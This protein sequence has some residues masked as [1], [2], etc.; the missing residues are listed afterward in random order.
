MRSLAYG[1]L[2]GLGAGSA[3][4]GCG[5]D[6]TLPT[7]HFDGVNE[8]GYVSY[9]EKIAE[10]DLGDGLVIPIAINFNSHRES[11]SPTL[12]KGWMMTLLESH[13]EP[14]DE[15]TMKVIMPHGWNY[16]FLR[17][18]NTETWGGNA[19]W[20]GQTDG[21]RFTITA[22]CGWRVK[23]DGGKIQE[24]DSP[25]SRTIT[26]KYNGPV[27]TEADIDNKPFL[28]VESDTVTGVAQD[29]II[30]GQKITIA[31][32]QRPRIQ[33]VNNQNLITGFDPSL[34]QL[35]YPDGK[36]ETY[37]FATPKDLT[38]TL[39][40]TQ[41]GHPARGITWD[42]AT[43]QIKTDGDW[44]YQLI[45]AANVELNRTN[46]KGQKEYYYSDPSIGTTVSE[47]MDG[48]KKVTRWFT[49]GIL[50]GKIRSI[51][52]TKADKAISLQRYSY[53]EK[54][55]ILREQV[56]GLEKIYKNGQLVSVSLNG[57]LV[58]IIKYIQ[59]QKDT[60]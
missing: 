48:I 13:V 47:S 30:A 50:A 40:I 1:F 60:E 9:W 32:D 38:P 26:I 21:S 42:P 2:A 57:N 4:L 35:Q 15:N 52:T 34:S 5:L 11:S 23:F 29:L 10:A 39:A 37:S 45:P 8:Q 49:S 31:Q 56:N 27:A 17:T 43:R 19:G 59:K 6:W 20:V 53:D 22:P 46:I 55:K 25:Q 18:P 3:A 7:N 58:E 12:G 51:E 14:I 33:S 44:T 41:A 36:T 24:I 16:Y 54:G 28:Q